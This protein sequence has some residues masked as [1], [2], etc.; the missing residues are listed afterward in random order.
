M[1]SLR[2]HS[3][4]INVILT[5]AEKVLAVRR[6]DL[7]VQRTDIRTA[8][9]AKDPWVWLRGIRRRG[10]EL[11]LVL[12][13]GT[14]RYHGGTDF[15]IVKGKRPALVLELSAGEYTRILL[16][17]THAAAVIDQLKLQALPE[18]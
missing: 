14:W 13:V 12:A 10:S 4:R 18:S 7:V 11:P 16:T 9:I 2:I 17:T 15:V 3:D 5:A 6:D 1:A 8:T